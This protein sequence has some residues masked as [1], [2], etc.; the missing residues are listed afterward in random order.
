MHV[1]FNMD[2]PQIPEEVS[3][4]AVKAAESFVDLCLQHAAYLGGKGDLQE[5]IEDINK[6]MKD[7]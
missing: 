5:A 6:C 3:E 7:Q 2:K 4:L 1:L